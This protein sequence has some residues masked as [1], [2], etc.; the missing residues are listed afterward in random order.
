MQTIFP[1]G[2]NAAHCVHTKRMSKHP[3][4]R[5]REEL[6][7]IR[8]SLGLTFDQMA[9]KLGYSGA[10]SYQYYEEGY[11]K[12]YLENT[13]LLRLKKLIPLGISE[14][15]ISALGVVGG[16]P[17]LYAI[18][19]EVMDMAGQ[20]IQRALASKG[21]SVDLGVGIA[22][23]LELYNMVME[24]RQYG[25]DVEPTEA[26]ASLVIRQMIKSNK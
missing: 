24:E 13:F 8:E 5:I 10:S 20:S 15:R 9:K 6:K 12:D 17:K 21:I 7:A 3:P 4:N 1:Y 22:A 2:L 11:N 16:P 14:E 18:D 23:T 26:L 25:A 19:H